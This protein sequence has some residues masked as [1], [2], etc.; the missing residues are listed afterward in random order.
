MKRMKQHLL[1]GLQLTPV[2]S[3]EKF[4]INDKAAR[5][6]S[7][8]KKDELLDHTDALLERL[9]ELQDA[10]HADGRRAL[11]LVLQGRDASGK[12]G[13]IRSVCGAFNPTGVQITSFGVPTAFEAKH[14]FLWRVHQA[15]PAQGMIGVFNRSHYEDVLV[16][17]ARK[18]VPKSV[19]EKRYDHI[20]GFEATL[21]DCGVVVRKCFLHVSR[22][23]QH[24][25]LAERLADPE[26]NWKFR[27]G[28]L[29]DRAL[30][31]EYSHAYRDMLSLCSRK[32]APWYIVPSDS[33]AVRNY[34][35]ARML[36]ETLEGLDLQYPLMDEDVVQEAK[37]FK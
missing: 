33:K 31:D 11:L 13:T 32:D 27:I 28:D 29:D 22:D 14:D 18:L 36:V 17:R 35:I 26:K 2:E 12:D 23:E 9:T 7:A 25:R 8:P 4:S 21:A 19:W 34:L 20:N 30:W 15:V 1:D 10:F 16:V 5:V 37:G 3:G 24:D 6:P